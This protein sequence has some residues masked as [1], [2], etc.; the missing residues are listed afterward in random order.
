MGC[1][2]SSEEDSSERIA[3]RSASAVDAAKHD[4]YSALKKLLYHGADVNAVDDEVHLAA[5]P[6]AHAVHNG[7]SYVCM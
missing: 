7:L 5:H 4:D 6:I 1:S 3:E 2:P